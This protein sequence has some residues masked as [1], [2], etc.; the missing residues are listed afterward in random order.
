VY[1]AVPS[2]DCSVT[3]TT[4]VLQLLFCKPPLKTWWVAKLELQNNAYFAI[5]KTV[6][7]PHPLKSADSLLL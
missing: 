1:K 7:S 6:T 4:I 5:E 2:R 3:E